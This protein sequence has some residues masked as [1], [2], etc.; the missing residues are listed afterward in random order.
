MKQYRPEI[1]G[2]RAIAVMA[3][4]I[5]HARL[6]GLPGGYLGVDIF[7]VISGFLITSIIINDVDSGS[8]SYARF[9]ERRIRRLLPAATVL[10]LVVTLMA[11]FTMWPSQFRSYADSLMATAAFLSNVHFWQSVDYF[12]EAPEPLLHT[13]S[14]AIEEQYY[15]LFPLLLV[16]SKRF[17]SWAAVAGVAF[18][19]FASSLWLAH[20]GAV[21]KPDVNYFFT[22]SRFWELAAGTLA[23]FAVRL[24]PSRPRTDLSL[25]GLIAVLVPLL[26]YTPATPHPSF[27]TLVPVLGTALLMVYCRDDVAVA[28]LLRHRSLVYI[29]LASYSIYLWH[30][31]V[32]VFAYMLFPQVEHLGL[33][34]LLILLSVALGALSARFVERPFRHPNKNTDISKTYTAR[35]VVLIGVIVSVSLIGLAVFLKSRSDQTFRYQN[36][37]SAQRDILEYALGPR[38]LI[39]N[40]AASECQK[41]RKYPGDIGHMCVPQEQGIVLWGDSHAHALWT[42]MQGLDPQVS[43]LAN[44]GCA[45]FLGSTAITSRECVN[46]NARFYPMIVEAKPKTLIL[47]AKWDSKRDTFGLVEDTLKQLQRD[48]PDTKI[49]MVGGAPQWR[50]SLP[51]R[52][53]A[54]GVPRERGARIESSQKIV[55]D[56][57]ADLLALWKR[58]GL[59]E[60][61]FLS[62]VDRYCQGDAC[63]AF[64]GE[65][66][67]PFAYDYGHVHP[68]TAAEIGK[69]IMSTLP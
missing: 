21:N 7:F 15:L 38:P 62:L 59:P 68:D 66:L 31:P 27:P 18:V 51:E 30:Q 25:V 65:D 33:T 34:I 13:W 35:Q 49:L 22:F 5:F 61:Q 54:Q 69:W 60:S 47:H 58:A 63:I 6:P 44:S 57:D 17:L 39:E 29:G 55:R 14:L 1:D 24:Y 23:A 50:P 41:L 2:L 40:N 26:I 11:W 52:L 46:A 43:Y 53:V 28:R 16:T 8:F 12:N 9:Y 32:F 45:P 10:L 67:V 3:V 36:T 48:L 19:I 42:G 64:Q 37:T 56:T 20:W 4:V